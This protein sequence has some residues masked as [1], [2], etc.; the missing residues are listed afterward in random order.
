[1]ISSRPNDLP[2]VAGKFRTIARLRGGEEVELN[3]D[4]NEIGESLRAEHPVIVAA[5]GY[6][7]LIYFS[8]EAGGVERYPILGWRVIEDDIPQPVTHAS[9]LDLDRMA[10]LWAVKQP[11]GAVHNRGNGPQWENEAAWLET[12]QK[13]DAAKSLVNRKA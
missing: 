1:M 8:E 13:R 3:G 5:A 9:A 4:I 12:M 10:L 2:H 6:E 7:L 11:D